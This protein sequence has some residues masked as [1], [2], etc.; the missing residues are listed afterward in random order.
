MERARDER[1]SL[2]SHPIRSPGRPR[3]PLTGPVPGPSRARP[4]PAAPR[5]P[6][7]PAQPQRRHRR[8]RRPRNGKMCRQP[9]LPL[10]DPS[11]PLL[12]PGP[13]VAIEQT[14][15]LGH[16]DRAP[17]RL[18]QKKRKG[19]NREEGRDEGAGVQKEGRRM[20]G[21]TRNGTVRLLARTLTRIRRRQSAGFRLV[22]D[23][24]T[25]LSPLLGGEKATLMP[26]GAA[27]LC[28][29]NGQRM[30]RAASRP[31][32]LEPRPPAPPRHLIALSFHSA[33]RRRRPGA[34]RAHVLAPPVPQN[35]ARS[36]ASAVQTH[37]WWPGPGRRA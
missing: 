24:S 33:S 37:V 17:R 21:R 36:V 4:C 15:I 18:G 22:V 28:A 3:R 34:R 27:M 35:R 23:Q 30:I 7:G 8:G 14:V 12:L 26:E 25:F 1:W 9:L 20:E 5:K 32:A 31:A 13:A 10:P 11:S 6:P 2:R 29:D 19:V 16:W